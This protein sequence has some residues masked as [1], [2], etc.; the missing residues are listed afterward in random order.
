MS[1][2]H[3]DS[4]ALSPSDDVDWSD[5]MSKAPANATTWAD[6]TDVNHEKAWVVLCRLEREQLLVLFSRALRVVPAASLEQIFG[7]HAHPHEVGEAQRVERPRLLDAVRAFVEAARRGEYYQ[8]FR[9]NSHNCT[10]KSGRTLTF[11]AQLDLLFDRCVEEA[12]GGEPAQVV[13]AY[14]LLLDLLRE[15]D[16]FER[17]DIV[18]F[19]DEG[20]TW[21]FGLNWN[22]ILPPYI[23]CLAKVVERNEFERRAEAV[24]EEFVDPWQRVEVRRVMAS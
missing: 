7:D 15:I 10:D 1:G 22:R 3:A 17:D 4:L 2:L 18:F 21:Q 16:R 5:A 9:V 14:D 6:I 12:V 19:A 23:R 8:D 13:A 11:E 20:G 24:I